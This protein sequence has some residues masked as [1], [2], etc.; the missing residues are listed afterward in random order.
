MNCDT[1][2]DRL[3]AWVHSEAADADEHSDVQAHVEQCEH[4]R[5]QV[6]EMRAIL[7]ELDDVGLPRHRQ[8]SSLAPTDIP[9]Y[10]IIGKIGQGGMGIVFEVEQENPRRR[11][12]LKVMSGAAGADPHRLRLFQ[13]EVQTLARLSHAGIAAIHDAGQTPDGQDFFV[14][15]KVD[16]V[17]LGEH[18]SPE[19]VAAK[20]PTN[21]SRDDL[22]LFCEICDAVSYAHQK[23]VIHR[24]LKP[25]NILITSDGRPKVLDFGLARIVESD[26]ST[27]SLATEA[28]QLMGTLAYMSPEQAQGRPEALDVRSDVYSLG[29]I[30]YQM[31]TGRLPYDVT[32]AGILDAVRIVCEQTPIHPRKVADR[33]PADLAT[34]ILKALNKD[35]DLRYPSV[36]ALAEDL[37]RYLDGF[38]IL[39]R[40]PSFTYQFKRLVSRH[41]A[42]SALVL[43]LLLSV[44]VGGVV[45]IIQAARIADES[46]TKSRIIA[47]LDSLYE[48]ADVWN[49]GRR[50]A[51]VYGTLDAKAAEL[52][53]ELADDPIV[54]ATVRNTIGNI[55]KSFTRF[56]EA[57]KHLSFALSTRI[58]ELGDDH[59]DTAESMN[60][61]C[62]LRVYQGR[63][64]EAQRLCRAA[65]AIRQR[66]LD[67]GDARI[68]ESLNNL[69]LILRRGGRS[70]EAEPL[71]R[72]ALVIRRGVYAR[73]RAG[74]TATDKQLKTARNNV[75]QTLNNLAGLL[76]R[77][78]SGKAKEQAR[79]YY[80][81]AL[82]LR[83]E[84]LG[85]DHPEVGKMYNNLAYFFKSNGEL[86]QAATYFHKALDIWRG[87]RGIGEDHVFIARALHE[88]ADLLRMQ[89]EFNGAEKTCLEALAMR[90]RIHGE[91]HDD[92]RISRTLL[93]RIRAERPDSI[94]DLP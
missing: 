78:D 69:G 9:G 71:Y 4:C 21:V 47:V 40:P 52:E 13:R 7:G 93:E 11:V 36:A 39:A 60:D 49:T 16:G 38:T 54:A 85:P 33:L 50:D 76:A 25:S 37:Q 68:A 32:R 64:K 42:I 26:G 27:G 70:H 53:T 23:G 62:E 80:T 22:R 88:V 15:E 44:A 34:I 89:E 83:R 14:M 66:R 92:A 29:V 18:L 56:E 90:K 5:Q 73:L 51:T 46:R 28:G 74:T 20:R 91:D 17:S 84:S 10:R 24:D 55:Y 1:S 8:A 82:R 94:E 72:E 87:D 57:E 41:K 30:L 19:G 45:A 67:N 79:R 81:E 86:D 48:A 61:L 58:R 35:A 63:L 43:L 2:H 12:A 75:A 6:E 3:W 31:T 65:L 59:L 77:K